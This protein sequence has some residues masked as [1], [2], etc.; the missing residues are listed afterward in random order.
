FHNDPASTAAS[1]ARFSAHDGRAYPGFEE[2]LERAASFLR[3]MMLRE[4]PALGSRHPVD[5]LS[6]LREGARAAG[7]SRRDFHDLIR[8]FTMSVADLLDDT[9]EHEGVKGSIASS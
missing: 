6:L 4:P 3:P 5:L 7:L 8:V 2:L 9:F 1:I